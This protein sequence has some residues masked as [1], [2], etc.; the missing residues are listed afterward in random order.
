METK[1]IKLK[2]IEEYLRENAKKAFVRP[3]SEHY[4]DFKEFDL[5]EYDMENDGKLHDI[6][7]TGLGWIS[8]VAKGQTIRVMIPHG[9][10][11]KESLSK[12]RK[13]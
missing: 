3:V 4:S 6:S 10:A 8:F 7:I 13:D 5:F 12:I 11:V 1:K 9:V 2:N